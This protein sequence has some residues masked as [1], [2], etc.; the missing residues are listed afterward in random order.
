MKENKES[1]SKAETGFDLID[2]LQLLDLTIEQ[3][4]KIVRA[5]FPQERKLEM[6]NN[7]E[8]DSHGRPVR[9]FRWMSFKDLC[10]LL[11][12]GQSTGLD[13]PDV[14]RVFSDKKDEIK[15]SLIS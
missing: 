5:L 15:R 4:I 9:Y 10:E 2:Q 11:G 1:I 3:R 12:K 7:T 6:I 8:K 13:N 14:V